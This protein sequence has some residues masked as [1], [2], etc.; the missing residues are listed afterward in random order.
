MDRDRVPT[1]FPFAALGVACVLAGG[2]VSAAIAPAPTEHGAWA[3][4]YLVLVAG[5]AQVALG[6]GQ[7]ALIPR[8]ASR[9]VVAAQLAGWNL[10]NAAVLIGTLLGIAALVDVGGVLLVAV[11]AGVA[12]RSRGAKAAHAAPHPQQR[13]KQALLLY[14][15]R[16]LLLL[17]LVSI[18]IGLVL[19]RIR[20]A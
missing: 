4:A 5:V 16:G 9:R 17:L 11:L 18:P 10:G 19:E 3:S 15:F 6:I 8:L 12:L 13:T 1:V 2:F 7:A 20:P 14:A